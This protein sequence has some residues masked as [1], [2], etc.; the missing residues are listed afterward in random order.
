MYANI[1]LA[2]LH[3]CTRTQFLHL[4]V[5]AFEFVDEGMEEARS[6]PRR[7]QREW[8]HGSR[9]VEEG[10]RWADQVRKSKAA[11]ASKV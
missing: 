10:E 3:A 2:R 4:H 1:I 8:G 11:L 9:R 5:Q 6:E 7:S